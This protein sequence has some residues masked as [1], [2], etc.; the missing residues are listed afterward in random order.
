MNEE[1]QYEVEQYVE[2]KASTLLQETADLITRGK[3]EE[4]SRMIEVKG[5]EAHDHVQYLGGKQLDCIDKQLE[6][7]HRC[8]DK[9]IK[10]AREPT[11]RMS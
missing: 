10:E 4:A 1:A 9:A 11:C 2:E 8:I 5:E 7:L 3:Y 6:E